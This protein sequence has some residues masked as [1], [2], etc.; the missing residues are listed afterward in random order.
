M[1][2]DYGEALAEASLVDDPVERVT[3]LGTVLADYGDERIERARQAVEAYAERVCGVELTTT[4]TTEPPR[5]A[6][7][8]L[9]D[10]QNGDDAGEP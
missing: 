4:S 5:S 3:R 1:L 7:D 8:Q 9:T 6:A 10:L 2:A